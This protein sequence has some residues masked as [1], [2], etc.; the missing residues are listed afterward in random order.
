METNVFVTSKRFARTFICSY[1][2][3]TTNGR[4]VCFDKFNDTCRM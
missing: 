2:Y 3:M 4:N 1:K